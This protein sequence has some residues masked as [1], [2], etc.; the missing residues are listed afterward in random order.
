MGNKNKNTNENKEIDKEALIDIMNDTIFNLQDLLKE[1]SIY[2]QIVRFEDAKEKQT[3]KGDIRDHF[4]NEKGE[5]Q[6][7][8]LWAMLGHIKKENVVCLNVGSSYNINIEICDIIDSMFSEVTTI[9]KDSVFYKGLNIYTYTGYNTKE[10]VKYRRMRALFKEFTFIEI[11]VSKY[12]KGIDIGEYPAINYAEVKFAYE[13]K[14]LLWN[15]APVDNRPGSI[16]KER[17]ILKEF[18]NL[19]QNESLVMS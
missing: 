5:S 7:K 17:E 11:D 18:L 2:K 9:Y 3:I 12:L 4:R 1:E 19:I 6:T 14:A 15:P 8:R 16:N 10:C 13:H